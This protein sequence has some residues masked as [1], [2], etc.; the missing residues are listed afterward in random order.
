MH[1]LTQ[2]C[3]QHGTDTHIANGLTQ[4]DRLPHGDRHIGIQAGIGGHIAILMADHHRGTHGVILVDGV[5]RTVCRGSH[6]RAGSSCIIHAIMDAPIPGRGIV[7]QTIHRI[8]NHQFP[9][10]RLSGLQWFGCRFGWICGQ[11]THRLR[12]Q[13]TL[14]RIEGVH[15]RFRTLQ[16]SILFVDVA[17]VQIAGDPNGNRTQDQGYVVALTGEFV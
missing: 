5:Y 12:S 4:T 16:R 9:R 11:N 10:H 3:L 17:V 7:T 14:P 2:R 1:M 8:I 15:R 6:L 13:R